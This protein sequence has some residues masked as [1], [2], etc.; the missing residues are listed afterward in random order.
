MLAKGIFWGGGGFL[1]FLAVHFIQSGFAVLLVGCE[2][3]RFQ[4][5]KVSWPNV[6]NSHNDFV[7]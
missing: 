6:R 7:A 3:F 5:E 4:F 1:A 2:V